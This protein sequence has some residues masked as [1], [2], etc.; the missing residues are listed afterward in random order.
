[1]ANN[2]SEQA[3]LVVTRYGASAEILADNGTIWTCHQRKSKL[4]VVAGDR[5]IW[6]AG[7]ENTGIIVERL[8]RQNVLAQRRDPKRIKEIA[9]NLDQ[10][11]I[12]FTIKP[13][14]DQFL[15]DRY[16][17]VAEQ[18]HITPILLITKL[19]LINDATDTNIERTA[20][21]YRDIGYQ[22]IASSKKSE[23]G[24][25]AVREI[26]KDKISVLVGQSGVGKSS[27]ATLLLPQT[28]I[29]TGK[30][31]TRDQGSH[32]T[33]RTTLYQLPDGGYLVDSPGVRDF[34]VWDIDP[35]ELDNFYI[36]FKRHKDQCRFNDCHH[37]NE[38]NCG[39]KSAVEK[40]E[41]HAS[42]YQSYVALYESLRE[43]I[44]LG[45]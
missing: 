38:P 16:I 6:Q 26:L 27:L 7:D 18:Q 21:R 35:K 37:I 34:A 25:D 32:T 1:M 13:S 30:L 40:G 17:A 22:V 31:T 8:A 42:R 29:S 33:S 24:L 10:I 4:P 20:E 11:I 28:D 43:N 41:I 19:D 12:A 45:Q 3:G 2:L 39:I 36:E 44:V 23:A 14:Y 9:A 5:V 15:I